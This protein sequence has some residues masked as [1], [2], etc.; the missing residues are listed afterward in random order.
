M[1]VVVGLAVEWLGVMLCKRQAK[2]RE[3][4]AVLRW[5]Q[6]GVKPCLPNSAHVPD[7]LPIW[8]ANS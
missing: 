5:S 4:T 6:H 7:D 8:V 3:I 2:V 1:R